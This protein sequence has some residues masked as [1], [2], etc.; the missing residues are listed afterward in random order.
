M[1]H[2]RGCGEKFMCHLWG[3]VAYVSPVRICS[4]CVNCEAGMRSLCVT[5]EAGMKSLC[6][7]WGCGDKLIV[8]PVRLWWEAYS[9]TCEAVVRS[10]CVTLWGCGEKLMCH[11]WGCDQKLM[12]HLWGCGEKWGCDQDP[13]GW[14]PRLRRWPPHGT[15]E[16][17]FQPLLLWGLCRLPEENLQ[18]Q[19][20]NL[21]LYKF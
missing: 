5:C 11:L 3:F 2:L 1:C 14:W 19:R 16:S 15:H 21:D 6:H 7:L 18:I 12:C 9:V 8:S 17:G 13:R 4:V 20:K 10:L